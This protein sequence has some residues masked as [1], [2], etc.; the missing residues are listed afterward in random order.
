MEALAQTAPG[1]VAS[2]TA[3]LATLIDVVPP[4]PPSWW[5]Q[6]I[7][8]A[9]LGVV[10]LLALLWA[11]VRSWRR[12]RANRYRR[13][14]LQALKALRP[15]ATSTDGATRAGALLALAELLKRSAL[16][17]WPRTQVAALSGA[18]WAQFLEHHAGGAQ[19]AAATLAPFV[20]DAQ[21]QGAR[22]LAR[23]PAAEA[24]AL[25]DASHDWLARHRVSA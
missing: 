10:L 14:A 16:A 18:G 4:P 15:A 19:H 22:A 21:Y 5:P 13:E 24:Q 25:F 20:A 9:V 6:T 12:W 8:W 7:G 23:L 2:G 17:A 11:A 3:T 1:L